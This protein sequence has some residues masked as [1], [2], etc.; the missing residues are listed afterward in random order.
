MLA[1]LIRSAAEEDAVSD[2]REEVEDLVLECDQPGV[3]RA[4]VGSAIESAAAA[5]GQR[6]ALAGVERRS[7]LGGV[8]WPGTHRR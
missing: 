1:D 4:V 2:V 5:C 6:R 7:A 3:G 8:E